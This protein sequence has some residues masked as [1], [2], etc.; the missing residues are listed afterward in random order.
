MCQSSCS[1]HKE[2]GL[3]IGLVAFIIGAVVLLQR[4][5]LVPVET[6][7]YL[8]PSILVVSGLKFMIMGACKSD[9][10]CSGACSSEEACPCGMENCDGS[11]E[12]PV[13]KKS[14]KKKVGK[15]K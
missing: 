1:P 6:W 13:A 8:W 14:M 9:S 12:M 5:D 10:C 4:F 7:D 11:C 2:C 3:W 15:K